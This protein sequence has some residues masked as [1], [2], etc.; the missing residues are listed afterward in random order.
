MIHLDFSI[1]I[2]AAPYLLKGLFFTLQITLV[3]F[4]GGIFFGS[5]L[6]I[7]RLS[8]NRVY[9]GLASFYVTVMRSLP[10]ILVL[11]WV[12]FL[13]PWLLGWIK[14]A[15][16]PIP[17]GAHM[18]AFITFVLFEAAFFAEIVRA[19]LRSVSVGQYSAADALG[20]S[21]RQAYVYVIFP[22]AIRNVLPILLTQTIILFQDSSLVYVIS[23]T[24]LLGAASKIAQ[25]DNRLIEMYIAVGLIY[26]LFSFTASRLVKRL[27]SR[28]AY[29]G[30]RP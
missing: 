14:G 26:F 20:L 27:Q 23:A 25:R 16:R 11:F 12:F 9:S 2:D 6:A 19:G 7:A 17:V 22:Q 5:L 10:L 15:G 8:P 13:A 4:L 29:R 1:L 21:K 18:T 24:D 28:L 3:G 30:A